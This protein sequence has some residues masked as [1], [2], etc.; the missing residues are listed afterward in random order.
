MISTV[1]KPSFPILFVG[2]LSLA[3]FSG[4]TF[5]DQE[6]S[7]LPHVIEVF[8]SAK[9]PLVD[10]E[11]KESGSQLR[12]LEI[13][14]YEID[15]IQSI[16]RSLS[17]DLPADPEQSK[18]MALQRIQ[19]LDEQTR[20]KMQSAAQGLAKAIQYGIDRYPAIVFDGQAV[21]YGVTDLQAALANYQKGQTGGQP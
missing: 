3:L 14:V 1:S 15:G 19:H 13:T 4:G 20:S 5:A 9:Y 16:E 11:A 17:L 2:L 10:T 18:L 12:G 7:N 8:T 21:V 6:G